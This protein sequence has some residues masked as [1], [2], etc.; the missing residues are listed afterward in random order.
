MYVER[1][2]SH[3][4][5]L[6]AT[7]IMSK[8]KSKANN[9][10]G[11]SGDPARPSPAL[12]MLQEGLEKFFPHHQTF[13]DGQRQVMQALI[14]GENAAAIFPTGGGKSLCYQLPGLLLA[15]E[16]MTLVVSPLLAL[17]KDQ[18]DSMRRLGHPVDLLASSLSLDEKIAV[19]NRVRYRQTAILYVSPEQLNNENS[20]ALIQS[21]P[22]ALLAID[23][24]HCISE[25]GHAFRPDYLR[26]SK[27]YKNSNAKRVVALT[28]TATPA[29]E[30]DI[31]E[32]F[33]IQPNNSIRT[34]F[35]RPNLKFIFT[36]TENEQE[37]T[38]RLIEAIKA[39]KENAGATIVYATI[40][41]T[42]E[43]VAGILKKVGVDAKC[44]HAGMKQEDRKA[45]QEWF[46][47]DN[48]SI[49]SCSTSTA[50]ARVVVAT[51]AF[52]MGV[53]KANIRY[54]YHYNLPKSLE[55]YA[56][57][58]GRAGR[59]GMDSHCEVFCCLEDV[60][61]LEA[62]AYCGSPSQ[63]SIRSLLADLFLK[64]DGHLYSKGYERA[65]SHYSL[66]RSHDM[67]DSSVQM[68]LAFIDIYQGL[69][70]QGTPRYGQYK[71]KARNGPIS[72]IP[73][74]LRRCPDSAAASALQRCCQTKKTWAHI[75]I[76]D[77]SMYAPRNN[78][79][80]ALSNLEQ[81]N[82]IQVM[83]S[84][85]EHIYR[86]LKIPDNL[87][88]VASLEYARFQTREKGELVRI[89]EVLAFFTAQDCHSK[90]LTEHFEGSDGPSTS[91]NKNT[92]PCGFCPFCK[93]GTPLKL[94]GR[95]DFTIDPNLW[96]NLVNDP[97]LPKDDPQLIAR[98]A[99]GFKSP[100]I[101]QLK[102]S[103]SSNFGLM[104]GAPYAD[105]MAFIMAKMFP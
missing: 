38:A 19:K 52:G 37:S 46:M 13:R 47:E 15:D 6:T 95:T 18:V 44:Y 51:I 87:D 8:R 62:F 92:F 75:N 43:K 26:L 24:A 21:V 49:H 88:T 89:G 77:A 40:Q 84:Q 59:D 35:F 90:L 68:L 50:K 57:E 61:Q 45:T 56:Q 58:I 74:L 81:M 53:D 94:K 65:V 93:S 16:G 60:A 99:L 33:S 30:K 73:N 64:R 22:I 41:K 103:K 42:T 17:M 36:P 71:V 12:V 67:A 78:L 31:R 101:N 2:L 70:S 32:K 11:G 27:F 66:G 83:P 69:V 96:K 85:V 104:E 23:E 63:K 100:R 7:N 14:N 86:F 76:Q 34:A 1:S 39:Q 102:L 28:A 9:N 5:F 29:V 10:H 72:A 25:W 4:T 82:L 98:F 3:K 91:S 79:T 80:T 54:V 55:G 48:I 20:V 105:L 97:N